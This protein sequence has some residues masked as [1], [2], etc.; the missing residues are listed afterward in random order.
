MDGLHRNPDGNQNQGERI[1]EG[2]QHAGTLI[3]EGLLVGRRPALK[4]HRHQRKQQR[5][6]VGYVMTGLRDEGQRMGMH[7]G[8]EGQRYIGERS[9]Q[10]NAQDSLRL[11]RCPAM[12]M[13]VYSVPGL[14]AAGEAV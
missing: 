12:N 13:H 6:K 7:P 10:R 9:Q 8:E 14:S 11:F 3:S 1:E 4:V 2:G 5:Q